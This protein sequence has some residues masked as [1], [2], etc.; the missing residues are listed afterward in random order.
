VIK[1]ARMKFQKLFSVLWMVLMLVGFGLT[2]VNAQ[3][4][5]PE[6]T[7]DQAAAPVKVKHGKKKAME[8][9]NDS[10]DIQSQIQALQRQNDALQNR[11][12][13]I[14]DAALS[15]PQAGTQA[16]MEAQSSAEGGDWTNNQG[17]HNA[18]AS[19]SDASE[20]IDSESRYIAFSNNNGNM[21]FRIGGYMFADAELNFFPSGIYLNNAYTSQSTTGNYNGFLAQKAHLSFDGRYDKM[22]GMSIGIEGDKSTSVSIGFFHAYAYA[23]FDKHFKVLMGKFTNPLSLEGLQPSADLPF[24]EA[25]MIADLT[26]NKDIGIM[27]VG[28][29][30]HFMDYALDVANGEQDNESSAT[31]PGKPA[32]AGKAITGRVFFTPWEKSDDEDLKGLGFGIAGSWDNEQAGDTAVWAKMETSLGGNSFMAYSPTVVPRGDFWHWDPQMYYYNGNFGLQSEL[33]QSIQQVGF[34]A[35]LTPVLLVNTA[36]MAQASWVIGGK[37]TFEGP[38]VDKEFDLSKGD[39]GAFELVA[40]VHQVY[41]DANSFYGGQPFSPGATSGL[42]T[43]AQVATAYGL[44]VNWWFNTHFKTQFDLERTDFSGGTQNVVSEQ[45]FYTR[46]A[47]IL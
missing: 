15:S 39:L 36:W 46:M 38:K 9:A 21:Q 40:R 24:M 32:Q 19:Y 44:A 43:G 29:F 6:P 17:M 3:D 2:Q 23:E 25:S 7:P 37:P 31:G 45:V 14:E 5:T 30:S 18:E 16:V 20:Y 41:M 1:G 27:A 22:F 13:A 10:T 42:A 28:S 11:I 4:Q 33:V 12:Q 8:A 47:F 35:T 34:G 26:P